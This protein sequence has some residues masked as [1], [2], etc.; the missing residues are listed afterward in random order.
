MDKAL[1][2]CRGMRLFGTSAP[3]HFRAQLALAALIDKGHR[4]GEDLISVCLQAGGELVFG[5]TT[6]VD[7]EA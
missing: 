7:L 1:E 6:R 5:R 4:P 3:T 2:E